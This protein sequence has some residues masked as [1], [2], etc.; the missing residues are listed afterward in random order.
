M[1]RAISLLMSFVMLFSI[2]SSV[3]LSAY[4]EESATSGKCGENVYWSYDEGS[5]TLTISGTGAMNYDHDVPWDGYSEDISTV[6]IE[7]GV[8]TI[9]EW[10]FSY[11]SNLKSVTIPDSVTTIGEGAFYFSS[12]TSVTIGNSVTTI[13]MKAFSECRS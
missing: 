13:R 8:T 4:A 2:L 3:N 5:K 6:E 9:G 7:T 10:A 12:L 1:K 11:C